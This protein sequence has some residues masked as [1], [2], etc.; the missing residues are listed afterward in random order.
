MF[1]YYTFVEINS[2]EVILCCL[3]KTPLGYNNIDILVS[4]VKLEEL[5][6]ELGYIKIPEGLKT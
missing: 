3:E 2:L 1:Q 6:K 5:L 4:R